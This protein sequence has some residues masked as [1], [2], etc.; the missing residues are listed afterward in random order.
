M[1]TSFI[2]LLA[3]VL[4]IA[5]IAGIVVLVV[6]LAGRGGKSPKS[7]APAGGAMLVNYYRAT[8]AADG[9]DSRCEMVLRSTDTPDKLVLDVYGSSHGAEGKVSYYAPFQAWER[10]HACI[11]RHGLEQWNGM[12]DAVAMDGVKIVC[13]FYTENGYVRVSADQMPIGGEAALE[14]IKN[15]LSEYARG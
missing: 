15:I 4:G 9:D 12:S 3:A 1:T 6:V 5:F 7:K 13:K 2:F 11:K 8:A 14:E 10:C